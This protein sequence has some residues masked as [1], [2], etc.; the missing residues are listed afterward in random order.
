[1]AFDR[2]ESDLTDDTLPDISRI[3]LAMSRMR[4]LIKNRAIGQLIM[5]AAAPDLDL[6]HVDVIE[7]VRRG[8]REGEVTI[9]LIAEKMCMDP[10]RAS[11]VVAHLVDQ[12]IL[13]RAVSQ[14]DARRAVIV[15]TDKGQAILKEK[16]R[17]KLE[18]LEKILS[19]WTEEE[20]TQF[21]ELFA[22]F[23]DEFEKLALPGRD[24]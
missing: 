24:G 3:S 10:S 12:G 15:L 14:A 11:R 13:R 21:A 1:M 23:V 5:S 7:L 6:A 17:V 2:C 16:R 9:G 20:V 22:R 19:G 4:V 18:M 8:A